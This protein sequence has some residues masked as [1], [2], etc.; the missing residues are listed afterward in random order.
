MILTGC[1]L[2]WKVVMSMLLMYVILNYLV[3]LSIGKK[4]LIL[5]KW[6]WF[7]GVAYDYN[8]S[9]RKTR[10]G[11]VLSIE[12]CP[13]DNNKVRERSRGRGYWFINSY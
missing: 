2:V 3:I 1:M 12:E 13:T 9:A 4:Q 5:G 8:N 7:V 10:A 11:D 6:V